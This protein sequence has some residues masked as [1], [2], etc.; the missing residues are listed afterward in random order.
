[1]GDGVK[2]IDIMMALMEDLNIRGATAFVHLV[3]NADEFQGAVNDLQNSSGASAKM[4]EVQQVSLQNQIQ[5]VK[6][7]LLAPFLM[8]DKVGEAQGYLNEFQ[9]ELH[10]GVQIFENLI[11]TGEDG[12]K[13][14]TEF[15]HELANRTG[16]IENWFNELKQKVNTVNSEM[17]EATNA[18]TM[19]ESAKERL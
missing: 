19:E 3:Q 8:S 6:N 2:D 15:G 1:M 5:L 7:A 4:A 9:M 10:R 17:Q 11:V 13:K 16:K 18:Y 12:E 14:L